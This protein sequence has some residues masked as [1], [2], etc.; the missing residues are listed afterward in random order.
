MRSTCLKSLW[1]YLKGIVTTSKR[2][3]ASKKALSENESAFCLLKNLPKTK[4]WG[5]DLFKGIVGVEGAKPHRR[6][7][8]RAKHPSRARAPQ[9]VNSKTVRWTV[10]GEG[11]PCDR[12]R[13][14][15]LHKIKFFDTL[16]LPHKA[17]ACIIIHQ[18]THQAL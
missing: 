8:Q 2:I 3:I 10:L 11:T 12:G 5:Q 4:I 18:D 9:G 14:L 1:R 6:S 15:I 13:P 7:P 17:A 16:R